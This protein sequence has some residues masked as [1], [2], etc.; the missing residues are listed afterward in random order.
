MLRQARPLV[1][2]IAVTF[3]VA[4]EVF[5]MALASDQNSNV[6]S[7]TSQVQRLLRT[8]HATI[9][10]NADSEERFLTE[11][12]LTTDEM[13]AMMKAGK[14]KNA[15]AFELGIAGQMADFINSG[16]PDIETFKKTPEFQ[17]Y[18]F[19]M[20]F[21]NDMRKDDDYKPL[22]EMIKKNKGETEAFKTL[23]V[24]VED[25]VS[26]KK[27]SPSAI[28]KLDPLNREQAIVE[29]IELALKKNQAL[30]KNKASLETIEH[31]VR[32]AAKSKPSTWKIFKIISRLKKL[33]LKR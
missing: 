11:P 17:K 3:L 29:K 7:I 16:L 10:V 30:N 12:P 9:K 14:S 25:S 19:Y 2:L 24:K 4:S 26:K 1:V 20:N 15:Y 31:T 6:A 27:A 22:V 33:K 18:E 21:L 32:M 13:M 5:S 23:L 8:H 28:V